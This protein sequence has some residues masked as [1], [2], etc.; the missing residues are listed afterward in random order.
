[1]SCL[2]N[3]TSMFRLLQKPY[4]KNFLVFID[5]NIIILGGVMSFYKEFEVDDS[6]VGEWLDWGGLTRPA[7]M[8][9]KDHSLFSVFSYL[10][11]QNDSFAKEVEFP[12]FCRGWGFWSE[13]HHTLSEDK[14]YIALFWNPFTT[15]SNKYIE[16]TLDM[17]VHK[18]DYL[19]YFEYV[20]AKFGNLLQQITTARLLEYQNLL[21]FLSFSL[22]VGDR[23][24]EMPPTPLALDFYISDPNKFIFSANDIFINDKRV[25]VVTLPSLPSPHKLFEYFAGVPYRYV[26]RL[27]TFNE[28]ETEKDMEKYL[29]GWC[30][31]R[32]TTLDRI[33]QDITGNLNGY[34][35][36][37]FIFHLSEK[38]YDNFRIYVTNVLTDMELP[39]IIEQYN[40][41]DV[42]WGS[43]PGMYLANITPPIVGFSSVTD[44]LI[45]KPLLIQ[46][47]QNQFQPL[48]DNLNGE[49]RT[50]NVQTGQI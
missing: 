31:G 24:V 44:L 9:Q 32:K 35:H 13:R 25:L 37:G 47:Q 5:Y 43:L 4:Q 7:I 8:E 33:K 26:R 38:E 11:W 3:F 34:C 27:L 29:G 21:D 46:G 10:P 14:D 28:E 40:L 17:R 1:M 6:A 12:E 48:I 41:K 16:N 23:Y 36:N 22:S 15:K 45:Q 19:A 2:S 18:E 39:F 49:G 20:A 30:S 50:E 42:W